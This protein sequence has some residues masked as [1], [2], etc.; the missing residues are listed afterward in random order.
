MTFLKALLIL[1]LT[2]F[3]ATK[4][5]AAPISYHEERDGF[6]N[7][8]NPLL[9][10]VG[11]NSIEGVGCFRLFPYCKKVNDF[12]FEIA[13][14]TQLTGFRYIIE[15]LN[16]AFVFNWSA[17]LYL[18][19]FD[20]SDKTQ[21]SMVNWLGGPALHDLGNLALQSGT[22]RQF[23]LMS[24]SGLGGFWDFRIELDVVSTAQT[25]IPQIPQPATLLFLLPAL[26]MIWRLSRQKPALK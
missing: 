25:Q 19:N 8:A 26:F 6:L 15:Q 11:T 14:E 22:Y 13:P 17:S 5:M 21:G 24:M 4:A 23:L 16:T 20:G 7:P 12:S 9:M 1:G 2:V 18:Q 3:L 10:G